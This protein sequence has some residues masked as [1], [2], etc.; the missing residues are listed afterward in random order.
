MSTA[1]VVTVISARNEENYIADTI[2]S[3]I[4]QSL[5]PKLIV[6]V[7]DGSV[8]KTAKIVSKYKKKGVELIL[9]KDR[10]GGPSML[11]TPMMALPF[12]IGFKFI[13]DS[14]ITFDY[15]MISGAD[16]IYEKDYIKTIIERLEQNKNLVIA[17]G[18]QYG[19][20]LNRDHARG[21]GRIIKRNF[22]NFYGAK[23][24]Y[25]SFLW[26]S[27][28]IFKAQ[29]LGF[30]V[31]GYGDIHFNS[32]RTSGTNVNMIRYGR[33]LRAIGYPI[34]IVVGRA[35][36]IIKK[37][38][39]KSAIDLLTGYCLK[40]TQRFKSDEEIRNYLSKHYLAQKIKNFI[41]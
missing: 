2:D 41:S 34:P 5:P 6:V 39:F 36:R 37:T 30:T 9:R 1:N 25:P 35:L 22:W 32:Q 28:I 29:M 13:E 7:D 33:M 8:D 17:S 14:K 38:G 11:G 20:S 21:A 3:L 19:E 12:N 40:P 23:Y 27:G 26:E 16:C 15:M 31:R 24:P 18:F 4:S 10:I